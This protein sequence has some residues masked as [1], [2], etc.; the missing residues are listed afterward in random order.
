[1]E[2]RISL[3]K[4]D[5]ENERSEIMF[6]GPNKLDN[7][8]N[9]VKQKNESREPPIK[10]R[11]KNESSDDE[12]DDDTDSDTE[13]KRTIVSKT[14]IKQS[15]PSIKFLNS[16]TLKLIVPHL[17]QID[18]ESMKFVCRYFYTIVP[19]VPRFDFSQEMMKQLMFT[20]RFVR[21]IK[22]ANIHDHVIVSMS[23]TKFFFLL[24]YYDRKSDNYLGRISINYLT[25]WIFWMN[26]QVGH[27]YQSESDWLPKLLPRF[28]KDLLSESILSKETIAHFTVAHNAK[29]IDGCVRYYPKLSDQ[30]SFAAINTLKTETHFLWIEMI[31]HK[32]VFD[33]D[34]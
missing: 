32:T 33:L 20:L 2:M 17:N 14:M 4:V 13:P 8:M 30:I 10:R 3:M 28:D 6:N 18:L 26:H 25:G 9:Q 7:M 29:Y 24:D 15:T 21:F 23:G 34:D 5:Q 22:S 31:Y 19:K 16:E 1:M 12:C 27:I 11:K